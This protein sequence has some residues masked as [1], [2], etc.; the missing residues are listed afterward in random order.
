MTRAGLGLVGLGLGLAVAPQAEAAKI[1]AGLVMA[2]ANEVGS[3]VIGGFQG[4]VYF[5]VPAVERLS[6]GGDVSWFLVD[7]VT[8]F[9]VDPNVH[10]NLVQLPVLDVY[11]LAG[12]NVLYAHADV[13]G[14]EATDVDVGLLLGVGAEAKLGPLRP[15]ADLKVAIH[16]DTYLA[17][18]GGL[19]IAF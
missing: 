15:Y 13:L 12:V 5:G 8:L 3:D 7:N 11:P 9:A 18:S 10:L 19:R 14:F 16:E 2:T 6:I 17:L 1:G 4:S